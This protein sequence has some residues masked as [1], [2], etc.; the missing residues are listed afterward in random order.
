MP[1]IASDPQLTEPRTI[2]ADQIIAYLES[3]HK[4]LNAAVLS[5][6]MAAFERTVTRQLMQPRMNRAGYESTTTYTHPCA[7][8]ARYAYQGVSGEP[9]TSRALLKF[10][11]GDLVELAVVGLAQLAGVQLSMNNKDLSIT[12]RDGKAINVHP[13]GHIVAGSTQYNFECK[14]CDTHTFE[15]WLEQGGPGNDWGYLTQTAVEVAAWREAGYPVNETVFVAVSTG[16]RQG[17]I[18]EWIIPYRGDLLQQWHDRRQLALG[19]A[20]LPI[21]FQA[22]PEMEFIKGKLIDV[23]AMAH[24]EP[25]PRTNKNGDVYGWDCPTGRTILPLTC[26]YCAYKGTCWPG[27]HME[28]QGGK[29]VWVTK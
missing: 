8:K 25:V 12:G 24:G 26:S 13:D 28:V 20:D 10:L 17:S 18:A 9:V 23:D 14:S 29:P 5:G 2:V 4:D 11:L 7:R 6:M 16:S 19:E 27:A 21:P 1:L 15:R 22:A 3:E